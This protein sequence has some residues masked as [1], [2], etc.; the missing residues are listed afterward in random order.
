MKF[1]IITAVFNRAQTIERSIA[2]VRDQSYKNVEHIVVDGDSSDGT[3]AL[4]KNSL[5]QPDIFISEP[6]DGIYDAL[7]KGVLMSSGDVI[8]FMHSDDF[9]S[10]PNILKQVAEC[11]QNS[12]VDIVYGDVVYF[13]PN[14][15][16]KIV[17]RYRSGEYSRR[18]LA[19]GMMPAHTSMF[20]RSSVFKKYGLF[21]TDFKIAADYEYLCRIV[22]Q[23]LPR[24]AYL[25][26]VLINMSLG[27]ISTAGLNSTIQLNREVLRACLENGLSTNIFKILSKYPAKLFEYV[28]L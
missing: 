16:S 6:D 19:W 2:S 20:F 12:G 17:R 1:S 15:P 18:N 8:G 4:I 26:E 23:D 21:K 9:Y 10:N 13:Y 5:L 25:H 7:N 28:K 22:S 24:Y 27:G 3:I 11:F 14:N